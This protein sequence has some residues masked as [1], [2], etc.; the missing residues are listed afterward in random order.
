VSWG[1]WKFTCYEREYNIRAEMGRK[2]ARVWSLKK[3]GLQ[4]EVAKKLRQQVDDIIE[5]ARNLVELEV[6]AIL[7]TDP[8]NANYDEA[9]APIVD[10]CGVQLRIPLPEDGVCKLRIIGPEDSARDVALLLEAKYV[11]KKFT[12]SVLQA[13]GQVQAMTGQQNEDWDGDM[14]A[15]ESEYQVKVKES[16]HCLWIQGDNAEGVTNARRT[17][18]DMLKFYLPSGFLLRENLPQTSINELRV[19]PGIRQLIALP[20]CA[21][22]WD[23]IQGT[24]WICGSKREA[25]EERINEFMKKWEAE[26][27]EKDLE[28]Y[29]VAMWLLGPQGSGQWLHRMQTEC[30]AK[31]K[32]CPNAL[33]VWVEGPPLK[34]AEGK[35]LIEEGLERLEQKKRDDAEGLGPGPKV[36]EVLSEQPP[37]M[38]AMM[39][40]LAMLEAMKTAMARGGPPPKKLQEELLRARGLAPLD[41]LDGPKEERERSRSRDRPSNSVQQEVTEWNPATGQMDATTVD[42]DMGT[43]AAAAT[44]AP[45]PAASPAEARERALRAAQ[46]RAAG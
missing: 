17:L 34:L 27:W 43:G 44:E 19:D 40:K 37:H 23:R 12:A 5:Q 16:Q 20:D 8:Q 2:A 26:H 45:A 3:G 32:V 9:I 1:Q 11:K 29:G 35:R 33:K 25:V 36:K 22:A 21:I 31:M 6:E 42:V 15:L 10:Q 24:A 38:R 28:D 4:G 30:G 18:V 46:E 14:R 41:E 39:E 13:P 7:E